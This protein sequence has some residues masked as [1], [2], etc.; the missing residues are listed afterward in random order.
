MMALYL[1]VT[2]PTLSSTPCFF[3]ASLAALLC[4]TVTCNTVTYHFQIYKDLNL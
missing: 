4:Q 1:G 3:L 2:Q